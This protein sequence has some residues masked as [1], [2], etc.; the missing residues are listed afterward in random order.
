MPWLY[1]PTVSERNFNSALC[2][3]L[4]HRYGNAGDRPVREAMYPTDLTDTGWAQVAPLIPVPAWMAERGGRPEGYCHREMIDPMLYLDAMLYLD[5]NGTKWR[6]LPVD[7][8]DRRC[9]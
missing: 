6:A 5:D 9:C 3:C 1:V 2:D 4:A 7:F 8:P